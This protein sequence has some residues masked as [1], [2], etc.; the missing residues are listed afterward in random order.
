[1]LFRAYK[2]QVFDRQEIDYFSYVLKSR[3]LFVK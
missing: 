1:M 3:D 2:N